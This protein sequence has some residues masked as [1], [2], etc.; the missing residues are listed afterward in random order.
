MKMEL[1]SQRNIENVQNINTNLLNLMNQK[2]DLEVYVD[3]NAWD[4]L[5]K[6]LY[7]KG[8]VAESLKKPD[9]LY[10][11]ITTEKGKVSIELKDK[12]NI[13]YKELM[14]VEEFAKIFS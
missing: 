4:L 12:N 9:H 10:I 6:Y 14:T 1:I 2:N 13:I 11:Y 5:K 3:K 7:K 8:I